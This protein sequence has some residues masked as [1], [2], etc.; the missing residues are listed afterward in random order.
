[1]TTERVTHGSIELSNITSDWAYTIQK[2]DSWDENPPLLSIEFHPGSAGDI[3][4]L[5]KNWTLALFDFMQK[6]TA[7]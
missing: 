3:M 4:V 2:P 5:R 6:P 1:M 7:T